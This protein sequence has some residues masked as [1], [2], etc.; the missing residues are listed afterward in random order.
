M[1][2]ADTAGILLAGGRSSRFGSNK[3]L[4]LFRGRPLISHA[5]RLLADLFAE[6]LLVTNSPADYDFLNWP[7]SADIFPGAGP[8]AG[9]HAALTK[10]AALRLFVVGCD[11]PLVQEPLVRLLCRADEEWDAVVPALKGG[12]EPLCAL[13]HKRCLPAVEAN[14]LSGNHKLHTLFDQIRSRKISEEELRCHDPQLL[15]FLN[16]NRHR[17]LEAV[18]R[19]D[20]SGA[21]L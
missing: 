16:I 11:M 7:M 4:A 17:D 9:I 12:L 14:L 10:V 3:A 15:S 20:H 5:A 13:Y 19:L 18:S 1:K 2:I 8:L 21:S 6:T